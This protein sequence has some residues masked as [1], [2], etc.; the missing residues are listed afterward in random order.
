MNKY[1]VLS[2][3]LLKTI[4]LVAM[5][6]DH[7]AVGFSATVSFRIL[8][9]GSHTLT[10]Y[11]LMRIIGRISF[12][13]YSFLLGEGFIHTTDRKKY[14]IRLLLF[15]LISEIPWNLVHNNSLFYNKQNVFFTLLIGYLGLCNIEILE[16]AEYR[17]NK[18]ICNLLLLL[19]ISFII[20]ADYGCTGF[21]FIL[22]LYISNNNKLLQ[23]V[24][25]SCI[26][27]SKWQAGLAFI[28]I[29]LYNNKRGYIKNKTQALLFY[30]IYPLHL[31]IIWIIKA[32]II[33]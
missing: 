33:G 1:R 28:P 20:N 4:A 21:A 11:R 26:L 32:K 14:G 16:N 6:I 19:L 5:I 17:D 22:F 13:I 23:A 24:I 7:I 15:A 3:S 8:S 18:S 25:G 27:P 31:L 29:S 2:G 10:L 12:P 30:L 9:I